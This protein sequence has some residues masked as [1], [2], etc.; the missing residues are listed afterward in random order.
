MAI[1]LREHRLKG[2]GQL[3]V[4]CVAIIYV[5]R[6]IFV[7]T[8]RLL[9]FSTACSKEEWPITVL[10]YGLSASVNLF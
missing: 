7:S 8:Y 5:S 9:W 10:S 2:I 6:L 1:T 4:N 3:T